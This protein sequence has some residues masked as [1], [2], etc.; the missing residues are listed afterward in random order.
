MVTGIVTRS[1]RPIAV[2]G[3]GH[4]SIQCRHL[5][6]FESAKAEELPSPR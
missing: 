6:D 4:N 5:T 3:Y 2:G 1:V